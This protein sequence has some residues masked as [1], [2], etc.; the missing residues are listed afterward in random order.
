[1]IPTSFNRNWGVRPRT[2]TFFGLGGT[3]FDIVTLPHDGLIGMERSASVSDGANSGFFPGVDLEYE[4]T[5]EL[6][7]DAALK[8]HVLEFEGVYRDARVYVNGALAAHRPYGYSRFF[9]PLDPFLRYGE[10]NLVRVEATSEQDS[11]WYAGAGIIRPVTLHTSSLLH[12]A[13]EGPRFSTPQIAEDLAAV[14]V[15]LQILNESPM[16]RTVRVLTELIDEETGEVVATGS[17]PLTVFP[18]ASAQVTRRL[19]VREPRLWSPDT[20][21]LYRGR[22]VLLDG[23]D[24]IDEASDT[25]GIRTL[26]V[27]PV[28]GMRINGVPIKLRGAC[29][30]HDNGPIGAATIGAADDRR[31]RLLREAGFNAIRSAHNPASTALLRACDKHGMLVMD[32]TF[33][34]WTSRKARFDYAQHF[35]EWWERDVESLV[36][37]DFNR[38]SVAFYSIGNEIPEV[39][40]ALSADLGRD[41]ANKIRQLDPTRFTV[42]AGQVILAISGVTDEAMADQNIGVNDIL[43]SMDDAL[44]SFWQ[45]PVASRVMEESFSQVDIAGYNYGHARYKLDPT[46]FPDRIVVGSET[47]RRSIP[48]NWATVVALP[49]IIG[50][51]CWTGWDYIGEVGAGRVRSTG[52]SGFAGFLGGFPYLTAETGDI[53]ITGTRRPASFF[54]ETVFDL[55]DTPYIA[56]QRPEL[57]GVELAWNS[58]SWRG[59]EGTWTWPGSEGKPVTIEVY[60][61]ADE[62]ELFVNGNSLG[63]APVGRSHG[64]MAEFETTYEP[65]TIT[66]VAFTSGSESGRSEWTTAGSVEALRL[67]AEDDRVRDSDDALAFVRIGLVDIGGRL[68]TAA[69]RAVTVVV[70]GPA[71]LQGLGSGDTHPDEQLSGPVRSTHGGELLAVVRPT[72]AGTITVTAKSDGL[73]DATIQLVAE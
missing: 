5:F 30:H 23:D 25:L 67:T 38:P 6:T 12:V 14:Q 66:A 8:R 44:D 45:S 36:G 70:D 54:R 59:M 10:P 40:N 21:H 33:D 11:R 46:E 19:F 35:A 1:M 73:A 48:E 7:H 32:E 63:R 15:D 41:L 43:S 37:R 50:D 28:H 29:V 18:G 16:R 55:R 17:A 65:G 64:F 2:S 26:E 24:I 27:D 51:F 71:V 20:P 56:V 49:H 31:I 72:G 60:S 13:V 61:S 69:I 53:D 34:S 42:N 4:K 3:P 62:V 58:F 39:G 9:V 47:S 68:N 22:I 52:E 57:H